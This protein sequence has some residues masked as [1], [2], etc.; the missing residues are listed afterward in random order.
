MAGELGEVGEGE[1]EGCWRL[2]EE[3]GSGLA[4]RVLEL[5]EDFG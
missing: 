3:T 2:S 1:L 4:C 5:R